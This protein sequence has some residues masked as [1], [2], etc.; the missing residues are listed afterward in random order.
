[1]RKFI[2]PIVAVGLAACGNSSPTPSAHSSG[3]TR[4]E[5]YCAAAGFAPATRQTTVV[6]DEHQ[7][8]PNPS[9]GA[10]AP[11][12]LKWTSWLGKL[13]SGESALNQA[14]FAPRERLT[15]FVAPK[16]GSEPRLIFS[17]CLPTFS[18]KEIRLIAQKQ[19][20][21][22]SATTAFFGSGVI[23][24]AHKD[25]AKFRNLL[26]AA[27]ATAGSATNLSGKTADI[28]D[29]FASSALFESLRHGGL[30]NPAGGVSRIILYSDLARFKDGGDDGASARKAG[31]ALASHT[32]FDLK[33]AD[34]YVVGVQPGPQGE[35]FRPFADAYFLGS[36][37]TLK[38]WNQAAVDLS[39]PAPDRIRVF[40]GLVRYGPSDVPV[41]IRIASTPDGRVVNSWIGVRTELETVTPITGEMVSDGQGGE[42]VRGDGKGLGQLWAYDPK[43]TL[44]LRTDMAFGVMRNIELHIRSDGAMT[45]KVFDPAIS[46]VRGNDTP[47]F[48]LKLSQDQQT[49]F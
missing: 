40:T 9:P 20:G 31:F 16:D 19:G 5:T 18:D 13:V 32:P 36:A 47:Y 25:L 30:V 23:E 37:G 15:V 21:V 11:E 46:A 29:G 28:G 22:G 38:G 24:T 39:E 14:S 7:I 35:R 26:G 49:Q 27:A 41:R 45:G 17:G 1:M 34:V 42:I 6:I 43:P 2:I 3:P 12:N 48:A 4:F 10:I 8:V 33:R 44:E